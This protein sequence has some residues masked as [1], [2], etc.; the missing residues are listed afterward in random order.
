MSLEIRD[1][2][3][4]KRNAGRVVDRG[5]GN[6]SLQLITDVHATDDGN[7]R[8]VRL[9]LIHNLRLHAEDKTGTRKEWFCLVFPVEPFLRP[10]NTDR[11]SILDAHNIV[12]LVDDFES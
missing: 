10:E 2:R 4:T 3:I 7:G 11:G 8:E 9:V 5:D 6:E 1:N 12:R